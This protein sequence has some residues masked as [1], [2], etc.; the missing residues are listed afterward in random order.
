VALKAA[1]RK[2][3]RICMG[4]AGCPVCDAA[5]CV[6]RDSGG[7][8]CGAEDGE[9]APAWEPEEREAGEVLEGLGLMGMG[10]LKSEC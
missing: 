8:D 4:R 2:C 9:V 3:E 10:W 5:L 1:N 6:V 7:G